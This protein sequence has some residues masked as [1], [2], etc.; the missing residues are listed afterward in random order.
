MSDLLECTKCKASVKPEQMSKDKRRRCGLS[1]WCKE[2]RKISSRT[3]AK[4]NP[5][6]V[7][8]Q[9]ERKKPVPYKTAR[10][11]LLKYRYNLSLEQYEQMLIAQN[12]SC[13]ICHKQKDYDL[14]VDHCHTTG[15]VRGLLCSPCNNIL[16]NANDSVDLLNRAINYLRK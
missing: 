3:W 10:G 1:S 15:K 6:K 8:A 2:C 5:E 9:E 16:G 13:D 4:N 14:Y 12:Y 7:Q 11:Y